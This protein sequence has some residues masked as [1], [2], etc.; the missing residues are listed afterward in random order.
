MAGAEPEQVGA[1]ANTC[2]AHFKKVSTGLGQGE[3]GMRKASKSGGG[4]SEHIWSVENFS[5][6]LGSTEQFIRRTAV[7]NCS[8][9]FE[10]LGNSSTTKCQ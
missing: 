3:G 1:A 8:I 9:V 7:P 5:F 6:G 10:K 4:P 2:S